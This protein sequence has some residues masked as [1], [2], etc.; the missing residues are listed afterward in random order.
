MTRVRDI[1][2]RD[3][4]GLFLNSTFGLFNPRTNQNGW[5]SD[6]VYQLDSTHRIYVSILH[7]RRRNSFLLALLPAIYLGN[8]MSVS[9]GYDDVTFKVIKEII[10]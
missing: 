4:Q 9:D 2:D 1:E 3:M 10:C 7:W 5:V 6:N 8:R